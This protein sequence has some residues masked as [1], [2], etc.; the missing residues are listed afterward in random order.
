MSHYV[1]DMV[2]TAVLASIFGY[3]VALGLCTWK[4]DVSK[5]PVLLPMPRPYHWQQPAPITCFTHNR[6]TTCN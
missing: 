4:H 3:V 5:Q 2:V 1:R 6:I